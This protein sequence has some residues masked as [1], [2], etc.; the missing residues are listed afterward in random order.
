MDARIITYYWRPCR[1]RKLFIL[2]FSRIQSMNRTLMMIVAL[3]VA[4]IAMAL[5][6]YKVSQTLGG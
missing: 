6:L 5:A 1:N 4:V 3:V 2:V